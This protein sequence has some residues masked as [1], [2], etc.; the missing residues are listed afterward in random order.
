MVRTTA[1]KETWGAIITY[2][3][4]SY[5]DH[6]CAYS[7]F[8]LPSTMQEALRDTIVSQR[9]AFVT[10]MLSKWEGRHSR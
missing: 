1:V 7:K 2:F 9:Q 6:I 10:L 3:I 8:I 4:C 5:S